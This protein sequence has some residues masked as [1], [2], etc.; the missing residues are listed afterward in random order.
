MTTGV[1]DMS[2]GR[3]VQRGVPLL[4]PGMVAL[5][6]PPAHHLLSNRDSFKSNGQLARELQR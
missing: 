2:G 6:K 4:G 3:S 1:L 5:P